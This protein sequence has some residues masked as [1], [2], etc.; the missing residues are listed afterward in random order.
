MAIPLILLSVAGR[1]LPIIIR[2]GSALA[3]FVAKNPRISGGIVGITA[4]TDT[5]NTKE[6]TEQK[7]IEIL[8]DIETANPAAHQEIL[9]KL[10][11]EKSNF[12]G[13]DTNNLGLYL[14]ILCIIYL[15]LYRGK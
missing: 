7:K 8:K 9:K 13:I 3:A 12:L 1:I 2:A 5:L 4:I 6:I 15:Y 11:E 14:L 10:I